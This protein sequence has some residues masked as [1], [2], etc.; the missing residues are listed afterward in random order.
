LFRLAPDLT[1]H[2]RHGGTLVVPTR[3]RLRAVQLAYAAA[4]LAAGRSVWGSPDVLTPA[5]FM[6]REAERLAALD[7]EPWPRVLTAAEEWLWWEQSAAQAAS[8]Q[9]FLDHGALA[10]SLQRASELAAAY[11]MSITA[12][13]PGSEAGLLFEAQRVFAARAQ[14]LNA[15]RV[16]ALAGRL[17]AAAGAGRLLLRGFDAIPPQLAALAAAHPTP[18][19]E[20]P[21]APP[22]ATAR[23]VR[24]ADSSAELAAI[25]AWCRTRLQAQPDARLLVMLPGAAGAR[26]RLAAFI[27]AELAPAGLLSG[28]PVSAV[29]GIEG[30]DPFAELPLP[31]HALT[32]LSVLCEEELEFEGL[33]SWLVAPHWEAPSAA[34]RAALALMLRQRGLTNLNLR[35]LFGALQLAPPELKATARELD[36]RLHRAAAALGEG[37]ASPRRWSE[38]FERALEL[39]GWPGALTEGSA[40]QQTRLRWRELLEEFGELSLSASLLRREAALPLLRSLAARTAY[41]PAEEDVSVS[42]SPMLADPVAYYDGIWVGALSAE[43]LPQ[44]VSPDPFLPLGD[45]RA[46]QGAT[47]ELMFSVPVHEE[48]LEVL[49]S[50]LLSAL[51]PQLSYPRSLWRP[52]QWRREGLTEEFRDERGQAWTSPAPLPGGTRVLTLQSACPFHAYAELRLGAAPPEHA[53]PGIAMDQRGRLLHAA[54]QGLWERLGDSA[55]LAALGEAAL[56]QLI[57]ECVAHAAQA[58]Q[59][60]PRGRRRR[61]RRAPDTQFDLF[62]VLSPALAREAARARRLIRRLCDLERTRPAFR[63]E[64]TEAEAELA[65]GGARIRMRLDRIDAIEA[66]RVILDYKSGR[67]GHPDWYGERPTHPQLL[68][69]LAASG[70]DVAALATV[71]VNAREVRFTGVARSS[72]LLPQVRQVRGTSGVAGDDWQHQ[73]RAWLALIERLI[74]AFLAGDARV[75]PAAGACDYCHVMDVCRILEVRAAAHSSAGDDTDE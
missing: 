49:P 59:A 55:T 72:D 40:A 36:G 52:A 38:R 1:A 71:N 10:Q 22:P 69:Y 7:P 64:A 70:T 37:S 41:R 47:Q 25:T 9:V 11:Q 14:A 75:D 44:P 26:E 53:E 23:L 60:D 35:V 18:A 15:T 56:E 42:V 33:A 19:G 51:E 48:D 21:P 50:P 3:Q 67:S 39:L 73:Q 54:L 29:V 46:W 65:L 32:A 12:A 31:A 68:A 34:Q 16:S 57:G 8:G 63:V 27:R 5:G 28:A 61:G 74:G 66:G 43:V 58:L 2:L 17:C 20:A 45:L 30:G 62:A 4:E 24:P 13:A 6:R